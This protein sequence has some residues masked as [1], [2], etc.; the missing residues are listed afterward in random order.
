MLRKQPRC[1]VQTLPYQHMS[2]LLSLLRP[3]GL[4]GQR[5][6]LHANPCSI[7]YATGAKPYGQGLLIGTVWDDL[8]PHSSRSAARSVNYSSKLGTPGI[9]SLLCEP[10][11]APDGGPLYFTLHTWRLDSPRSS[12][13]TIFTYLHH[14]GEVRRLKPC[15]SPSSLHPTWKKTKGPHKIG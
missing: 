6:G 2:E 3:G 4:N 9:A 15:S 10:R 8:S 5:F 13:A 12:S 11:Q 1:T 7:S 14:L